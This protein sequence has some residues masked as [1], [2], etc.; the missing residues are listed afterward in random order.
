MGEREP[1]RRRIARAAG[2]LALG[3]EE[4]PG[5]VADDGDTDQ[6]A[7]GVKDQIVRRSIAHGFSPLPHGRHLLIAC[8]APRPL[9]SVGG[10]LDS[11]RLSARRA[12]GAP[13]VMHRKMPAPG[14]RGASANAEG[15]YNPG[16]R[17][18]RLFLRRGVR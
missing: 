5:D 12:G 6:R 4:R 1:R 17:R 14:L 13:P 15:R 10:R 18:Q 16:F 11:G 9:I 3:L 2:L 8:L 7:D